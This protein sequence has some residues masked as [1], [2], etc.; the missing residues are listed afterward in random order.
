[1]RGECVLLNCPTIAAQHVRTIIQLAPI[2]NTVALQERV[3]HSRPTMRPRQSQ[4]R[5]TDT[6]LN[7]DGLLRIYKYIG[8]IV[9]HDY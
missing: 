6:Y 4:S 5:P 9:G 8:P 3:T 7:E 2:N 1:M